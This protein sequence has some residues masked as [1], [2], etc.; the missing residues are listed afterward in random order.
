VTRRRASSARLA[1]S[2]NSAW[3]CT[4][5]TSKSAVKKLKHNQIKLKKRRMLRWKKSQR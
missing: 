1:M 4:Q 3:A 5:L 2:T